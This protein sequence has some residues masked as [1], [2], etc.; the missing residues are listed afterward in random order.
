ML[1]VLC[2]NA[3]TAIQA[4]L[5]PPVGSPGLQTWEP[6]SRPEVYQLFFVCLFVC[7][8]FKIYLYEYT[9]AV[10]RHTRRLYQIPLQVVM[11]HYVVNGN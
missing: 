7:F 1:P 9:V 3:M 4:S 8:V 5:A 11:S 10:S 6:G 2:V